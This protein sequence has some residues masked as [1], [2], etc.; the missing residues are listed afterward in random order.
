MSCGGLRQGLRDDADAEGVL[1][2]LEVVAV[3]GVGRRG[4]AGVVAGDVGDKVEVEGASGFGFHAAQI[5]DQFAGMEFVKVDDVFFFEFFE[6]PDLGG[7]AAGKGD[8]CESHG[9]WLVAFVENR[10]G[11]TGDLAEFEATLAHLDLKVYRCVAG[12]RRC[13]DVERGVGA[14][15]DVGFAFERNFELIFSRVHGDF[16][17]DGTV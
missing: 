14:K 6:L 9:L 5:D 11:E 12:G 8:A 16:L 13:V 15:G 10:G 17:V 4:G 3:V 2:K 7:E 1:P